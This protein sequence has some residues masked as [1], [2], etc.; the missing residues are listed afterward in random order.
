MRPP[1]PSPIRGGRGGG[2]R[3]AQIAALGPP[4]DAE[5]LT[6]FDRFLFIK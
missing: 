3:P 6:A 4:E 2:A 5:L 1:T